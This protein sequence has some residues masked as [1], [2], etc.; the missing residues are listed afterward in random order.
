VPLVGDDKAILG[1]LNAALAGPQWFHPK[2]TPWRQMITKKANGAQ[3]RPRIHD[4]KAPAVSAS[5]PE[6]GIISREGASTMGLQLPKRT[7]ARTFYC[8]EREIGSVKREPTR[9][10]R[11]PPRAI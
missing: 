9:L 4:D 6:D 8:R 3:I 2:D 1:Q 11:T 5:A 10:L 7:I